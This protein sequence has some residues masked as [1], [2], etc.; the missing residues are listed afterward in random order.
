MDKAGETDETVKTGEAARIL[1]VDHHGT[2]SLK[3]NLTLRQ[4]GHR[5]EFAATPES[6]LHALQQGRFAVMLLVVDRPEL[7]GFGILQAM[8]KAAHP[9]MP[10]VIAISATDDWE[11]I[12]QAI[13]LGATDFLPLH[14]IT[15]I[16]HTRLAA[17]L[18]TQRPHDRETT[19]AGEISALKTATMFRD[20]ESICRAEGTTAHACASHAAILFTDIVDSTS[21]Q[22][23][24][25]DMWLMKLLHAHN[26]IVGEAVMRHRGRLIKYT[27]DGIMAAFSNAHAAV[28][29][30]LAMQDAVREFSE[31]LPDFAFQ[32]RIGISAGE[33][34]HHEGDIFGT[35]VN[36]ASRITDKAGAGMIACCAMVRQQCRD[37]PFA[38]SRMGAFSLKGFSG[39]Q[40]IYCVR[41][42]PADGRK[43]WSCGH[44][45]QKLQ[46]PEKN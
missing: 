39:R 37:K 10:P 26:G 17:Y 22:Q 16:L 38:F 34:I 33:P 20:Q 30:A 11:N 13:D 3:N 43:P 21:R 2:A 40:G 5:I 7:D 1:L 25:G 15:A 44:S 19:F 24:K 9:A 46:A 23:Q 35:P 6:A 32:I 29:A 31:R 18:A 4:L 42:V 41:P 45:A 36:M 8:Q 14:F 12:A 28:D 27:G